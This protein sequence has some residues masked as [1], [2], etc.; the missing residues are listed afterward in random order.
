[1]NACFSLLALHHHLIALPLSLILRSKNDF[2]AMTYSLFLKQTLSLKCMGSSS[3]VNLNNA[4]VT[5]VLQ[6]ARKIASC[7]STL[8]EERG[9]QTRSKRND[10]GRRGDTEVFDLGLVAAGK[11]YGW[12]L[13][14]SLWGRSA[15][16]ADVVPKTF[17]FRL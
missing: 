12:D 16:K 11:A 14:V 9:I 6:V 17:P 1:M 7:N 5:V 15:A 3:T 8:T 4:L 10:R 13:A 2:A